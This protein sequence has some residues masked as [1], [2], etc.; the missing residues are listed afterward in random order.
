MTSSLSPRNM[1]RAK[2]KSLTCF[3]LLAEKVSKIKWMSP[4]E[5]DD[6]KTE[7]RKFID[8]ECV[9][10]KDKFLAFDAA[11][12]HVDTFLC[13]FLHGQKEYASL[14]KVGCL[15]LFCHIA[16]VQLRGSSMLMRYDCGKSVVPVTY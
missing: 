2:D 3:S 14:W 4:N 7:Y 10:F 5:A 13:T 12:D 1:V 8:K 6:V 15:C 9:L 16:K 11:N